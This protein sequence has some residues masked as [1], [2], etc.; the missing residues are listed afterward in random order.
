MTPRAIVAFAHNCVSHSIASFQTPLDGV[1]GKVYGLIT[2]NARPD[3]L[4]CVKFT[5]FCRGTTE[6]DHFDFSEIFDHPELKESNLL[7]GGIS[8]AEVLIKKVHVPKGYVAG[9]VRIEPNAYADGDAGLFGGEGYK[10]DSNVLVCPLLAEYVPNKAIK[11][12]QLFGDRNKRLKTL[13]DVY[14]WWVVSV[15]H[16]QRLRCDARDL[17]SMLTNTPVLH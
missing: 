7:T 4:S 5:A 13:R 17:A 3:T 12:E 11:H 8:E 16:L 15:A 9:I 10:P 6:K 1:S 14:Q 2:N